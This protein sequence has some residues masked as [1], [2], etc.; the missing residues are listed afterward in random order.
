[1]LAKPLPSAEPLIE[2]GGGSQIEKEV[3][4]PM[5]NRVGYDVENVLFPISGANE[6]GDAREEMISEMEVART[7][8]RYVEAMETGLAILGEFPEEESRVRL[9]LLDNL[10]KLEE[11]ERGLTPEEVKVVDEVAG[12]H[13][14]ALRILIDH[15]RREGNWDEEIDA[16]V[17]YG[18]EQDLEK[19]THWFGRAARLGNEEAIEWCLE[20]EVHYR[21]LARI[22]P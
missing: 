6:E 5:V 20:N 9:E 22:E 12:I 21:K 18:R 14:G 15:H 4:A 10:R 2:E 8:G 3:G 19:A 17:R 7:A 1:M 13:A 11:S 16:L